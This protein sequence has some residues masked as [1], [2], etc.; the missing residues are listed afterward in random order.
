[1]F[2]LF[3][4]KKSIGHRDGGNRPSKSFAVGGTAIEIGLWTSDRRS[5]GDKY[6]FKLSRI[7]ESGRRY[8]SLRAKDVMVLPAVALKLAQVFFDTEEDKQT[9][10]ELGH[11]ISLISDHERIRKASMGQAMFNGA[12]DTD[13]GQPDC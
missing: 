7:D 13:C 2:S 11:F 9:K 8:T 12:I 6:R 4:R 3:K 5:L 10:M 1:M